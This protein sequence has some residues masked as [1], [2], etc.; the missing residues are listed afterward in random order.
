[1]EVAGMGWQR[2]VALGDRSPRASEILGLTAGIE[3]G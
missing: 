3:G 1:M 2:Y